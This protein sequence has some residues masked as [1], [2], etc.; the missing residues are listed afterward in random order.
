[1]A[2][3]PFELP[4]P[5]ARPERQAP[6][7][8]GLLLALLL[9][10]TGCLSYPDSSARLEDE[11]ILT[12]YNKDV[13]FATYETFAISPEVVVFTEKSGK[14]TRELLDE[15]RAQQLVERVIQHLT[16]RGYTQVTREEDPDLGM[17]ISVLSGT[18]TT[19]YW[20]YWGYYWGY[21]YYPYYPYYATYSYQVGTLVVDAADLENAPPPEP[22][23]GPPLP[24]D[25]DGGIVGKLDVPW[26]GLVYGVL[27]SSKSQN[28]QRALEGIDQAFKQSAYFRASNGSE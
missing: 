2:A 5:R 1:M 12:H 19:V 14:I 28:L 21:P 24:I 20:N 15:E 9:P 27:S 11:I 7:L 23:A 3:S 25:P 4:A 22:D 6:A 26:T 16:D 18:V 13:D 10:G 8:L 17:T